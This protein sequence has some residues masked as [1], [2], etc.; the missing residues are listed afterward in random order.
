MTRFL[1]SEIPESIQTIEQLIIWCGEILQNLNPNLTC[2][3]TLDQ[4]GNEIKVR[5]IEANKFYYTAPQ[6]PTWRYLT[7]IE[8]DI[9]SNHQVF[10]RLW[11]HAII[12]SD[13]PIPQQ[14]K[15]VV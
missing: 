2:V 11:D 3:E 8:V 12:L 14:M 15:R 5:R 9:S 4:N 1:T 13:L 7:R 10:G 6:V